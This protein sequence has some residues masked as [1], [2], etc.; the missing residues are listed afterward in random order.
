VDHLAVVERGQGWLA[1]AGA[2]FWGAA[3]TSQESKL[4]SSKGRLDAEGA[5]LVK[6]LVGLKAIVEASEKAVEQIA[7]GCSMSIT[8]QPPPIVMRSSTGG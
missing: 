6:Q 8:G 2:P 7:L 4:S 3:E 1:I 5:L